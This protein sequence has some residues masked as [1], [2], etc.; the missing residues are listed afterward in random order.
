MPH[1]NEH[2]GKPSGHILFDRTTA[3]DVI[4]A[5]TTTQQKK[6][7]LF[8]HFCR[9]TVAHIDRGRLICVEELV[10]HACSYVPVACGVPVGSTPVTPC[11]RKMSPKRWRARQRTWLNCSSDNCNDCRMLVR[12]SSRR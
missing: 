8:E 9:Q 12:G 10:V 2:R 1:P 6:H 4:D 11:R 3:F 5:N 7:E